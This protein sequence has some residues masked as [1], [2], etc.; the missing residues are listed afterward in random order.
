MR[1]LF[2]LLLTVTIYFTDG[3]KEEYGDCFIPYRGVNE[4]RPVMV[5]CEERMLFVFS[6]NNKKEFSLFDKT[7]ERVDGV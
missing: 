4:Y 3:H 6:C 5:C 2:T 1:Y 7:I